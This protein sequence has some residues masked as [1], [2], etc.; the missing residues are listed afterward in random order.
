MCINNSLNIHIFCDNI[1]RPYI[2]GNLDKIFVKCSK[3][4]VG[5][6]VPLFDNI[7]RL[8]PPL[9]LSGKSGFTVF[10]KIL[11][12]MFTS[13]FQILPNTFI[14]YLCDIISLPTIIVPGLS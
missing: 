13:R 4:I 14:P 8:A 12:T 10:P 1:W 5:L 2:T 11:N 7:I 3:H 9:P 6:G